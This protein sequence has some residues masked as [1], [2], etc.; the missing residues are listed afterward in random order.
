MPFTYIG[1]KMLNKELSC[2]PERTGSKK[3]SGKPYDYVC[4]S[5]DKEIADQMAKLA[6]ERGWGLAFAY[7]KLFEF[8]MQHEKE[9]G[10]E[11]FDFKNSVKKVLCINKEIDGNLRTYAS[12]KGQKLAISTHRLLC[13]SLAHLSE[14]E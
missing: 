14:I 11:K 2:G 8:G 1:G 3:G 12:K 9:V 4:F 6:E 7:Q 13:Y 10:T 5:V